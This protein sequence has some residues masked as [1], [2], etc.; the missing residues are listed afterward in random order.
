[1]TAGRH[2]RRWRDVGATARA[3]PEAAVDAVEE[4]VGA[5]TRAVHGRTSQSTHGRTDRNEVQQVKLYAES[6]LAELLE[7]HRDA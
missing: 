3:A 7:S 2:I 6:V 4:S 1:V 5:L